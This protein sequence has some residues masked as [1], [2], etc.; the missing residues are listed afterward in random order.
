MIMFNVGL[1]FTI[2]FYSC[3]F[4]F[5]SKGVVLVVIVW[6][7]ISAITTNVVSSDTTYVMCTRY[8][9]M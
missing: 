7:G 4:L 9:I 2:I 6:Y 5:Q 1:N 8:N 3:Y